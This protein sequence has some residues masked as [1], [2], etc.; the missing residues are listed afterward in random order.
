MKLSFNIRQTTW[1]A[2]YTSSLLVLCLVILLVVNLYQGLDIVD[3]TCMLSL[4][5]INFI[6]AVL[7]GLRKY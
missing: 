4:A 2:W 7:V 6:G 1:E 5:F 3:V